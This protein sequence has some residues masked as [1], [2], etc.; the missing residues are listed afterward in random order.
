ME[1]NKLFQQNYANEGDCAQLEKYAK[2][3]EKE[4]KKTGQVKIIRYYPWAVIER[5]FRSQGGK[6]E[7]VNWS[8]KVELQGKDLLPNENG[9]LVLQQ[10]TSNALFIHLHGTWQGQ[11]EHEYYPIFDNQSAKIIKLPDA[12]DL[13]T[14]KQRGM[15]R[16]IARLSGI[17]LDIF[18]QQEGQFEEDKED[19]VINIKP[20]SKY[21]KNTEVETQTN[22]TA[23]EQL[24]KGDVISETKVPT[25]PT[26]KPS[27]M[28]TITS[29]FGNE[30]Q[31]FA[32]L[33][34]EVRKVIREKS[35]QVKAKEFLTSKGKELLSQL[36]YPLLQELKTLLS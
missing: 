23:F 9:E 5:L 3:I 4:F 12:L 22:N 32:D 14:A 26:P 35:M 11:E 27:V 25:P 7:V 30:S 17:G 20:K 15:V 21:I 8:M 31:E 29:S 16:L 6:V 33:L 28:E 13:N 10:T 19:N 1:A 18:E 36:D 2:K 24:I 34:L